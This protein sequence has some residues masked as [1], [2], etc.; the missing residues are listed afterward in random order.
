MERLGRNS[1]NSHL[2]PSSDPPGSRGGHSG[3]GAPAGRKRGGQPGHG[4]SQ[5]TLLPPEQVDEV[6]DLFPSHCEGCAG[7]LPEI[8]DR[9]AHRY[10]QVEL[11]PIKP[12]TKEWRCH[13]VACDKCGAKTRAPYD[14]QLIPSSPF[15]PRLMALIAFL[16]GVYHVSRRKTVVLLW[17]RLGV[18]ISLGALV[19]VVARLPARR[20]ASRLLARAI[21]PIGRTVARRGLRRVARRA[22]KTL[23]KRG[24]ASQQ[25]R[26][27]LLQNCDPDIALRELGLQL[28]DPI[29]S[30]VARHAIPCAPPSRQWTEDSRLD[31]KNGPTKCDAAIIP[32]SRERVREQ[33]E[34]REVIG[35]WRELPGVLLDPLEHHPDAHGAGHEDV[36][37]RE[38]GD[39]QLV[40]AVARLAR[41]GRAPT[42]SS[43]PTARATH[44]GD[45][46][47]MDLLAGGPRTGFG[48]GSRHA[49][50]PR[51]GHRRGPRGSAGAGHRRASSDGAWRP[52]PRPRRSRRASIGRCATRASRR[53]RRTQ[54][55]ACTLPTPRSR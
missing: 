34:R 16:T 38:L 45:V 17:E 54:A 22:A 37:P 55:R 40:A 9:D 20:T 29:V 48:R 30:P 32:R 47:I 39:E 2:P 21:V 52:G 14:A 5:R 24:Y 13:E 27:L 53:S 7:E 46:L 19:L 28:R 15:G 42:T 4:G 41:G 18:R 1:R 33:R 49:P 11:P 51:P 3:K 50:P 43:K 35:S 31:T 6:V 8:P 44:T 36:R 23:L 10:Q 25:R 12:H 26:D